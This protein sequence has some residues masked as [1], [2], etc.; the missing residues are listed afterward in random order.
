MNSIDL[1][2]TQESPN[3]HE[4]HLLKGFQTAILA[5]SDKAILDPDERGKIA[6]IA[7]LIDMEGASIVQACRKF[8]TKCYMFKFVSDIQKL[9]PDLLHFLRSGGSL[10]R[11]FGQQK[12][13]KSSQANFHVAKLNSA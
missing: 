4:P 5:I 3:I 10:K 2:L 9:F 7:E 1:N 12:P 13:R 6:M 11:F 8:D